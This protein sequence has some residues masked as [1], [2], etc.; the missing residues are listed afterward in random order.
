M[1]GRREED[2]SAEAWPGFV[3]MLSSAIIMFIF[4][5]MIASA[6]LFFHTIIFKSKILHQSEIQIKAALAQADPEGLKNEIS[7]LKEENKALQQEIMAEKE[8]K[9]KS[10]KETGY[11]DKAQVFMSEGLSEAQEQASA[12]SDDKMKLTIY[13]GKS[14][15]T[16]SSKTQT[17]L[18]SFF[19]TNAAKLATGE[20]NIHIEVGKSGDAPTEAVARKVAIARMFNIRSEIL[21]VEGAK[22]DEIKAN[23]VEPEKLGTTF[24]WARIIIEKKG[25]E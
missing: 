21:K 12:L 9:V 15:I 17:E 19:E 23:V 10:L 18:K 14:T 24:H 1:S 8:N 2:M 3:D 7:R 11:L 25:A 4:F 6:S 16:V 13:F 5:F 20:Y 22:R